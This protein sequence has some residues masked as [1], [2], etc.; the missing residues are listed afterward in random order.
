MITL[1]YL[2]FIYSSD[3]YKKYYKGLASRL[4]GETFEIY[5][6]SRKIYVNIFVKTSIGMNWVF[7][8]TA[9]LA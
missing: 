1:I 4:L 7:S 2:I 3:V 6:V 5:A 8:N 9:W